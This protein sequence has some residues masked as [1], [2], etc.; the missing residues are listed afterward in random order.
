MTR[1]TL[2][3]L[4]LASA[5]IL[6]AAPALAEEAA[7]ASTPA[8]GEIVVT[9]RYRDETLQQ[10]PIAI[11]AVSGASLNDRALHNLQDLSATVPS[12]D[13]RNGS[14]NKDRTV[15]IRGVG[16]ISTSPGV[17]PS[18][19]TVLDGVVLTRPGQSTLDVGEVERIEVL[20][21][22]QGTLF[23]KNAS[24]GVINIVTKGPSA[25]TGGYGEVTATTDQEYRA[26][27]GINGAIT[28]GV[29]A[30][31]DGL[32][33]NFRGNV[34][35]LGT[36]HKVN[37]FERYGARAKIEANPTPDLKLLFQADYLQSRDT[38]LSVYTASTQTAYP[39]GAVT[40]NAALAGFLSGAG[41]RPS[42]ANRT[43]STN[44]DTDV[45]DKNAGVGLTADWSLPKGY[46]LTSI[47]AY[48]N[49]KNHQHQDF[50]GISAISAAIPQGEDYGDVSSRQFSQE[51]RL[52]SPKGKFVD[53]VVGAYYLNA[54][55]DERYQRQITR[56]VSGAN[57]A[58]TGVANYGVTNNN[59]ALF[60][61]ANFNFT[62]NFRALAGYRSVWDELS[63][64]HVRTS[65]NDPTNA[66]TGA[67]T[68]IQGYHY[69]TG[70]TSTRGDA[71][72]FGLQLDLGA[73]AQTYVTYSRGYKGPAYNVFFN[74]LARDEIALAP[75][76][77]KSW[78]AGIKG[79]ALGHKITYSLAAYTT[80]FANFQAN[81]S[82]VVAGAIVTRLINAGT[83]S[84]KGVEID[85]GLHPIPG[86]SFDTAVAYNDAKVL[87]FNCPAGAANS[88]NIDGQVLPYAP[89]WKLY[90]NVTYRFGV[91]KG[92]D[93]ELQTDV[94]LK[95]ATQYQLTQTPSS[96]QPSYALLNASV[97]LLG[98][99]NGWQLRAYVKNIGN[100]H[101]SNL[102]G[103][104][105][106]AGTSRLVPRDDVRYGGLLLRK[107][108]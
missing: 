104:G 48:R 51:L 94:S 98:Q 56:V 91:A 30:R 10:V 50:D 102:L 68:G 16:T 85:L 65:T 55:T 46:K 17:E 96:I 47:T 72:R 20:R 42:L 95:S 101:Y 77:S 43:V 70:R 83:A 22:P 88:C 19:S 36:G 53:Y 8:P 1:P 35:N 54:K 90:E 86:L 75:E 40:D 41:I 29:N 23:G 106:I 100:Q 32:Y 33:T 12:V 4:L 69:G 39:T 61:E 2:R 62:S 67:V 89:K 76:T 81:F 73:N 5:L 74:M 105:T 108:F 57:V 78:E 97:A 27:A 3:S 9:A 82:D 26:K 38:T 49:W 18:V 21:G 66:G 25:R 34:D 15:F 44:F 84:S 52:T 92:W 64:Y 99:D 103:N 71:Y 79:S 37:G 7:T 63:F 87:H 11:T 80:D 28:D 6:P 59:Y 60:G 24:A 58:T 93:L 14:S 45:R 31:I 107:S 13:F